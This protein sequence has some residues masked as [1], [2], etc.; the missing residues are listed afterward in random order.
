MAVSMVVGQ[1]VGSGI[2]FKVDDVL[3][4]TNGNVYAGVMGFI[5]VGISVVF[6]AASMANYPIFSPKEGGLLHY[7][8]FR[9]GKRAAAYVGWVY[10]IMFL[11][12]L[13][14][15]LLTVSGIY[16]SHFLAEFI[17]F[18]P[19]FLHYSL[20]GWCNGVIFLLL[21]IFRPKSS[22]IFLQLTAVLKLFPLIFIAAIG[23]VSLVG[24]D[25]EMLNQAE[26]QAIVSSNETNFWLLVGASFIPITFSMDGWYIAMQISGEIKDSQKN[27][28][29]ALISGT[30]IVLVVYVFYYLGIV[31]KMNS[32]EIRQL[33][34]TYIIE[35]SRKISSEAGAIAIQ[36]FIIIS[37]LGT[38]NGLVLANTRAPY[39][40]YN[41]E[42]SKKFLNLG[43]ISKRT[44]MPVNSALVGFGLMSIYLFIFYLSNT[45]PFLKEL[46]YDIS[47]IPILFIYVVNFCLYLGLFKLFRE[48]LLKNKTLKYTML[49]FAIVGTC[50]VLAGTL[51]SP[52]GLSY[53]VIAVLFILLGKLGVK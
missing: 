27:L 13:A 1:M 51:S 3:A 40:F 6:S 11:P 41:L 2:F 32:N 36:L 45:N 31:S 21:N 33:G 18:E 46:N 30:L 17:H 29:K 19:N 37:V 15:V 53:L 34:D 28:P 8:E 43:N 23:I 16:I 25:A 20:I 24:N 7:V 10:F 39:Q 48:H 38:C 47:A 26:N 49:L 14:G 4:S 52:N 9:Y 42:Y 35:F 22:G 44:G 5:I 12:L 50:V